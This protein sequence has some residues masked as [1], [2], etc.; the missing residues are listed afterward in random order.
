MAA[1]RVAARAEWRD[2]RAVDADASFDAWIAALNRPR[3]RALLAAA[4]TDD[5]R[6]ERHDPIARDAAVPPP[7]EI[8]DGVERVAGW[9]ARLLRATTFT[10]AGAARADG[11]AWTVE[12]SLHVPELDFTNGGV[13][14]ARLAAD[15]RLAF[16]SHRP[17]ALA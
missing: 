5:V 15:G 11:D 3:D 13:W 2:S 17:F 10:R 9:L 7:V 1:A 16:L 8:F 12:Y 4:V 14:V 6:V